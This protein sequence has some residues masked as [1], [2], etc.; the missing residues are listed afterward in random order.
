MKKLILVWFLIKFIKSY[1]QKGLVSVFMIQY[2]VYS[3]LNCNL[4]KQSWYHYF[5]KIL[6]SSGHI[7]I[8][9]T[10]VLVV[11]TGKI[12]QFIFMISNHKTVWNDYLW[13]DIWYY[14]NFLIH[15]GFIFHHSKINEG[16]N[17]IFVFHVKNTSVI[18]VRF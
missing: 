17:W 4:S 10:I 7:S 13:I 5:E 8:K 9:D 16:F 11:C 14:Y 1:K 18:F 2:W 3:Q 12:T 15:D 6:M